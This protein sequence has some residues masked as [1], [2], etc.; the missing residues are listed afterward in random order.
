MDDT[1]QKQTQVSDSAQSQ[2]QPAVRTPLDNVPQPQPQPQPTPTGSLNK[3][4]E[5]APVS[6]F[7]KLTETPAIKD[8]EVAEAGV[9]EV[10]QTPEITPE[11]EKIGVKP[12]AEAT[13][14]KVENPINDEKLP[15]NEFQAGQI[16]KGRT[17]IRSSVVWLAILM[18]KHFKQMRRNLLK[19]G[20]S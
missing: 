3:E 13:P 20:I 16:T 17:N 4:A 12:S 7:V 1:A 11:H 2:A 10:V 15:L 14:V 5:M 9:K 18:L 19:K 6:D 8:K